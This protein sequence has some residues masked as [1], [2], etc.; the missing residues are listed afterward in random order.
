MKLL[1]ICLANHD[2]NI[3]Y[4]DGSEL[5]YF[6]LERA[7]GIKRDCYY[8]FWQWK[9]DVEKLWNVKVDDVDEI[10]FQIENSLYDSI[11]HM[12][13][14]ETE[15]SFDKMWNGYIN[16]IELGPEF[17]Y[18]TNSNSKLYAISHYYAHALSTHC[19]T[20]M[21]PDVYIVIDN[22]GDMCRSWGVYRN[23]KLVDKG[24]WHTGSLGEE[25]NNMG[26]TLNIRFNHPVDIAGKVMGLQSYGKI[27]S[28]YLNL[29]KKYDIHSVKELYSLERYLEYKGDELVGNL[30]LLDWARTVH[31]YTGNMLVK[32]FEK[33]AGKDECIFY[34]GGAAQNVI[35]NTKIRKHF[36]NLIIPPHCSDEGIS[37]GGIEWLRKKNN[38]PPIKLKN[39]PYCQSDIVPDDVISDENISLAAKLLSEGKI[40]GWY[41]GSGE[42]GPRALGNRSILMDP[43]IPNARF[44]LNEVKRRENYRPF[45]ASILK[46]Y[47]DQYFD[48]DGE[49]PYMLYTAIVKNKNLESIKHVDGTCRI[50]TVDDKNIIFKKLLSEFNKITG[51]PI[52][53]NTSL[54]LAGDGLA[55]YPETAKMIFAN[56]KLDNIFIG[57]QYYRKG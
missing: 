51:C 45:G 27:D 1:S 21:K 6:K 57:N 3:S 17:K 4:F 42:V 54:N 52:L 14:E 8:N 25:I 38:L 33:Y 56:T 47:S 31:E 12:I 26:R 15:K 28:H 44:I 48:I 23:D 35:W 22:F 11:K 46:E 39:F 9:Y 29:S 16:E 37:L 19:M 20:D 41:Q 55:G 50:Q 40:I 13:T 36:K 5:R 10:V 53:L 43:R 24:I 32:F 2:G 34:S 7:T 49:D 30:S 18:I